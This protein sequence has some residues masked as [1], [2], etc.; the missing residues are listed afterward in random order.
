MALKGGGLIWVGGK[1]RK[2]GEMPRHYVNY[3]G[4]KPYRQKGELS[5]EVRRWENG[6]PATKRTRAKRD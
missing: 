6:G 3:G 5:W 4:D 2:G 1:K